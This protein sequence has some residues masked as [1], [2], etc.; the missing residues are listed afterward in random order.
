MSEWIITWRLHNFLTG[1][2]TLMLAALASASANPASGG[3]QL[4]ERAALEHHV[5]GLN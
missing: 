4:F 1:L 3:Y 5:Q 2:L